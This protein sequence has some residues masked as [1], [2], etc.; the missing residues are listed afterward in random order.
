LL[1][2]G[3]NIGARDKQSNSTPLGW[4]MRNNFPEMV[5]FLVRRGATE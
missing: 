3:A 2:A 4:A 5:E 1:D